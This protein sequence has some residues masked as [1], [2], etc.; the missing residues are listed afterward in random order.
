MTHR[1]LN[2]SLRG[3]GMAGKFLLIFILARLLPPEKLGV[4]GL[5]TVTVSY[6]LYF[7]GLDFYTYTS[8]AMLHADKEVW[9]TMLR[10][11]AV[12]FVCSYLVVLPFLGL[13]FWVDLLPHEYVLV[14]YVLL[15]VEHLAQELNRLLITI[16]KP[17]EA[18]ALLFIRSGSWC[19]ALVALYLGGYSGV[20]LHVV[21]WMWIIADVVVVLCGIS[22]LRYL[23]WSNL[24]K[25]IDWDWICK[26]LKVA[27]LLLV[28][29]LALR[30]I[31]TVDRYFVE[32]YT[33]TEIT[34]VYTLYMG[35]C[36]SLIGFVDAAVFSFRYPKLVSLYKTEKCQEFKAEKRKL[37]RQALIVTF[38]LAIAACLVIVPALEWIG[39]PIYLQYV[40]IFFVL[41]VASVCYVAG[42][43]P[44]YTLYAMGLD[45]YI[46]RA[47]IAGL[48]AFVVVSMLC[49]PVYGVGGVSVALL[50]AVAIVGILKQWQCL[51]HSKQVIIGG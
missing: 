46:V 50:I 15:V 40:H 38:I 2:L 25:K 26:G 43:I 13:L 31:L 21:I 4:Y 12:L 24:K 33:S 20:D 8:R 48:A 35:I 22:P 51:M 7:L 3:G 5:L 39:Q 17:L 32:G 23:P 45:R 30:G 36:F 19:Y 27:G 18:G 9:P 29:T 28:G 34:G 1:L 41:L 49:A 42:H 37:A 16:G 10:D 14:F 11:Q 47:H 6:A 44:H